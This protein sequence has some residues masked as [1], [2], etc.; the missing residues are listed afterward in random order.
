INKLKYAKEAGVQAS[1]AC[2]LGTRVEL[3]TRIRKWAL[4]RATERILLLHGAAGTGKSAIAHTIAQDLYSE[5]L[6]LVPF[7]AFNCSVQNRSS[8]QLIPTWA[9]DLAELNSRY[10]RYLEGLR[11]GDLESTDLAH[12]RNVLF[13]E[14]LTSG[15]RGITGGIQSKKP[16]IFIIDALDECPQSEVHQLFLF[17]EEL[18]CEPTLP[19]FV[20]FLFTYRPD[21]MILDRF[22]DV[23]GILNI[24]IDYQDDTVE[25]IRKFVN[26][27]LCKTQVKDMADDVAKAAQKLF[28]CAAVLCRE[29]TAPGPLMSSTRAQI[30][31][32][33]KEGQLTSLYDSYRAILE[34]HISKDNG[35]V[36]VFQHVMTWVFLVQTPQNRQVLSAIAGV[37]LPE[38]RKSDP[39]HML[40]WL[41]SLLSGTTSQDQPISPLHTSLRDFL[42]N[43][44][45]SGPFWVDLSP[46]SHEEIGLACLEIM[47]IGLRF[48]MCGLETSFALNSKVKNLSQKVDKYISP[49]LR[50]ACLTTGHH[51]QSTL[52]TVPTAHDIQTRLSMSPVRFLL[53]CIH[54]L[55]SCDQGIA[56]E[57]L[58]TVLLDYIQFE[59][60]FREGYM[61]S[62]PQVY[63][64]GLIFAPADS[65]LMRHYCPR[66]QNL[67]QTSG[68][69]DIVWPPSETLVGKALDGH[70]G[71]VHSIAFSPNG[72]QIVSGSGDRTIRL[73]DVETGQQVGKALEGHTYEVR[74]VAFSSDGRHI[75]SG[76]GDKTIRL[77]DVETG[78][79]VG[80]ALDGH[81][82]WVRSVAFSSDGRH[83]FSGSDD[84][85]IRLW[86]V[87]TGKQVGKAL[88]GHTL[89][90][91]SV[92]FSSDGRHIVSGSGDKTIRLWDV[93]TGQQV[94]KALEGHT[95]SVLSVAF[96]PDGR[97]IISGSRDKTIRLWD[98]ETGQ[99]VS[100][101]LDGHT[102]SVQSVAFS[103]DG[104]H[105]VSGSG[106]TKGVQSVAFSPNDRHIVSGSFDNTIRLW[107]VA[108]RKQIGKPL[109]AHTDWVCS[110]AFSSDGRHI[111]SGSSDMT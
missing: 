94:G 93:E 13:L 74:S 47:N 63:I 108:R 11:V 54:L 91:Q 83:I 53:S 76:S 109:D 107:D 51:L 65:I 43:S 30:I 3:L 56:D 111:V 104:R 4:N 45:E 71:G 64:S 48:N 8:S 57:T 29:L 44:K 66:F 16:V 88:D 75:I 103:P 33:L 110:V 10:R 37:L 99:R 14:G 35:S 60:R 20:R 105:I 97:H 39:D 27:Q 98:V 22:K 28:E 34:I 69:L 36:Q 79:Q 31:Q 82:D 24:N 90:V 102:A 17:L 73:W 101:A 2:L 89:W 62:A 68:A 7:F 21:G 46:Q 18:V 67:I 6:A 59:K 15:F 72:R 9:K 100:K 92:A 23:P 32:R 84:N 58:E 70:T 106:H 87:E 49:G 78:Q 1:K 85:T 95:A 80:K 25:D 41:G 86:D 5:G 52:S 77:W 19:S 96:S 40:T 55:I 61:L 42:L 12:Q 50:Y 81:T 38:D 26:H